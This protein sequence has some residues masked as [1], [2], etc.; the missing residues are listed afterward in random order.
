VTNT[1]AYYNTEINVAVRRGNDSKKHSSLL[2]Y[3]NICGHE[4][5][6]TVTN[7]LAY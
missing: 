3:K 7:T 1:L 5:G 4:I 2:E 6:V